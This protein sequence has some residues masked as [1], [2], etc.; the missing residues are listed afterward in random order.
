[1]T[2]FFQATLQD[3]VLDT[4]YPSN[5]SVCDRA[6][7]A[8][9]VLHCQTILHSRYLDRHLLLQGQKY[10]SMRKF[11]ASTPEQMVP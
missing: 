9:C 3:M 5:P 11:D 2:H 4:Y 1:M 10:R 8:E 7:L 6:E